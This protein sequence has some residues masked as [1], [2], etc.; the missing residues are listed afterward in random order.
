MSKKEKKEKKEKKSKASSES[1][2][3]S[4]APPVYTIYRKSSIGM[5]LTAALT[6]MVTN[7]SISD[8]QALQ[9]LYSFDKVFPFLPFCLSISYLCFCCW[10]LCPSALFHFYF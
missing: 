4:A 1:S 10:F 9:I 5:A 3:S 2:S 6:E 8:E 7:D